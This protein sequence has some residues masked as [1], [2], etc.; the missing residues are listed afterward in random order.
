MRP[1]STRSNRRPWRKTGP[2]ISAA[3]TRGHCQATNMFRQMVR[4]RSIRQANEARGLSDIAILVVAFG[5]VFMAYHCHMQKKCCSPALK[6]LFRL[7]HKLDIFDAA[8]AVKRKCKIDMRHAVM[9]RS[10]VPDAET[11]AN[12]F[13]YFVLQL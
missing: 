2:N 6:A 13:E 1:S 5:L 4:V 8:I 7:D 3:D 10:R 11:D 9:P 12:V